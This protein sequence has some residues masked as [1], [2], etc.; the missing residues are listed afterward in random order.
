[1]PLGK[2]YGSKSRRYCWMASELPVDT[3][4][5]RESPPYSYILLVLERNAQDIG[6]IG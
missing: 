1:M 3:S 4:L 6:T 5:T 2:W